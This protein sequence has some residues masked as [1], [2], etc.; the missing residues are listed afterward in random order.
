M[1]PLLIVV[2]LVGCDDAGSDEPDCTEMECYRPYECAE[3][4]N[5]PT[6][7]HGCCPCPAGQLDVLADCPRCDPGCT[8]TCEGTACECSCPEPEAEPPPSRDAPADRP[9]SVDEE[10]HGV[11]LCT[12]ECT[13][14]LRTVPLP[15]GEAW[16]TMCDG[17]PPP[18]C[19]A[20]SPCADRRARCREGVCTLE[21]AAE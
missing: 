11:V 2:L 21:A 14:R 5:G 10:C 6:T 17:N 13:A 16:Q 20:Q 19:G 18:N 4:C 8:I 15:E 3:T 12:C 9:C 1:R 7:N